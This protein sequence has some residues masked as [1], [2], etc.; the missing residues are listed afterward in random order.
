MLTFIFRLDVEP[1][2]LMD[3]FMLN[4]NEINRC[5]ILG[6][7]RFPEFE[8]EEMRDYIL[9]KTEDLPR[10]RHKLVKYMG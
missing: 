7:I 10:C 6:V 5:N 8:F 1:L 2:S 9:A 3:S 4:D